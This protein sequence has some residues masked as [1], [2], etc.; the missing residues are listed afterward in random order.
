M[1]SDVSAPPVARRRSAPSRVAT[2]DYAQIGREALW[3][4][5]AMALSLLV[6][7]VTWR[8]WRANLRFP[9]FS[10]NGDVA[11]ELVMVKSIM[12]HGWYE[13]NP[14]LAA[15]LGQLNYDFPALVGE[16]G[17]VM[18]VKALALIFTNPAVVM[19]ALVLGGFPLIALTASLVLRG[20]DFSRGV[21]LVCAVLFATS[22]IH[23]LLGPVQVMLGLYIGIP[24]SGYLILAVLGARP[25][26]TRRDHGSG[27]WSSWFSRRTVLTVAM[28]LLVGCLG[29]DYAEFTCLVVLICGVCMF[30]AKRRIADLV[31]AFLVVII[32]AIPVAGSAVPDIAYRA[33]H[34]TNSVVAHRYPIET[35]VYGLQPIQLILPQL[36]DRIG[37][38]AQL[39]ARI[40]EDLDK[41]LPGVPV[42]LGPQISLGLLSAVGLIWILWVAISAA[43]T[44]RPSRNPLASQAGTAAL[45]TILLS[46]GSGGSVLFAYLVTAQL[47]VWARIAI[48][49]GFFAVVGL[50]LLLER[51]R[52]LFAARTYGRWL[53]G[54]VLLVA[55]AAGVFEG[56]S[57]RFVPS[58]PQFSTTW[59][60]DA[61]FVTAIQHTLP[62]NSM[63]LELPYIPFP[64]ARLPT[65]MTSYEPLIP[66][67]HSPTLRWSAGAMEGRPTD[68]LASASTQPIDQLI[69]DAVAAGFSGVYVLRGG[70]ADQGVSV[71]NSIQTLIG[72]PPMG[73]A[74]GGAAFFNLLP[75]AARL[76]RTIPL[77]EF[78]ATGE[79]TIYP[80]A[81][82]YGSGFYG[83]E[84]T[85]GEPRW[86]RQTDIVTI[87]NPAKTIQTAKYSTVLLTG[88]PSRSRVSIAW[89]N[90]TNTYIMVN[91]DGYK[92]ARSLTLRPGNNTI[93]FTTNA[94]RAKTTPSD[95]RDLHLAFTKTS[96]LSAA[97]AGY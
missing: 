81:F 72:V 84:P 61:R 86:G 40:D 54:A 79:A 12:Q 5:A 18:M 63:V 95:T 64:E 82:T 52:G 83:P 41:G 94:P 7:V 85:A 2:I 76:R 33:T 58:Y 71:V 31:A 53:T 87:N 80:L 88:Y 30:A 16:F 51:V 1:A 57:N 70:Y 48:L 17:K 21:T 14:N 23:F 67:L 4:G 19:N 73:D 42:N 32:I 3:V 55:L 26:F 92:V 22:P 93:K 49:V 50:G 38:F 6:A 34:G 20:L 91:D 68:W 37:P 56:T 59:R 89:P 11:Y 27:R 45:L 65:G 13:S 8:L 69:T 47:R 74:D 78:A 62:A 97:D 36:D 39:T 25:L 60:D 28:A 35:F 46:M 43:I 29:L 15:P 90:G 77:T 9:I 75:Y 44:A 96:F 24:L 10:V 66:Y